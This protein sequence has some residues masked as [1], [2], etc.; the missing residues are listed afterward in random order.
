[1]TLLLSNILPSDLNF[2]LL[3]PKCQ[4][5]YAILTQIRVHVSQ[6][7]SDAI[8]QFIGIAPPRHPA[9]PKK[10]NKALG[11]PALI[12]CLCQFYGVPVTP[13][14]LIQPL[15]NR[16]FIEKYCMPRQAQ[17]VGQDQQQQTHHHLLHISHHP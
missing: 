13:T 1:M 2:D 14:K 10:S 11:F 15:I 6:L 3:L 4:L 8:Y 7:I 17:Q 5:I 9:N 16:S 12:T